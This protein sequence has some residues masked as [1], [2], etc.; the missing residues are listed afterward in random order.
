MASVYAA[1][2]DKDRGMDRE[3]MDIRF[4]TVALEEMGIDLVH[5]REDTVH[6]V[7]MTRHPEIDM[8]D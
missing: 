3:D 6:L 7:H 8:D 4:H 1:P 2:E 5:K